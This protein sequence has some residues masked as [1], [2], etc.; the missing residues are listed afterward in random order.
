M[1]HKIMTRI[2]GISLLTLGIC[3]IITGVS[4]IIGAQLPDTVVR[5]IGI[6]DLVAVVPLTVSFVRLYIIK[7]NKE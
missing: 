2:F 7:K 5:I 4:N 1:E 6:I 3:G